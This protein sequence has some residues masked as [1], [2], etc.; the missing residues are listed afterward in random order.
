MRFEAAAHREVAAGRA[1]QQK[2]A[3]RVRFISAPGSGDHGECIA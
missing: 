1:E 3:A 2:L